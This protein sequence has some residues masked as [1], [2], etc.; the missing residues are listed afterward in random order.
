MLEYTNNNAVSKSMQLM[1]ICC[2]LCVC[3]DNTARSNQIR[4]LTTYNRQNVEIFVLVHLDEHQ[5]TKQDCVEEV[6][7]RHND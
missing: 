2:V 1:C 3:C 4:I 6:Q 5:T 7:H